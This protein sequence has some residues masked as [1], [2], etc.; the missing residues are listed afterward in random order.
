MGKL[1]VTF[2][3]GLACSISIPEGTPRD[4]VIVDFPESGNRVSIFP[5]SLS[6]LAQTLSRDPTQGTLVLRVE[7]ECTGQDGRDTTYENN[8]RLSINRDAGRA[9]WQFF[10]TVREIESHKR[11]VA[12]YPVVPAENIQSNPLVRRCRARWAYNGDTIQDLSFGGIPSILITYDAWAGV[13]RRLA[14]SH[15]VPV[16]RSF[17]LDA[18][19]F[20]TSGDPTRTIIMA[21]AAW[22]IALREYLRTVGGKQQ[23]RYARAAKKKQSIPNLLKLVE[24][25]KERPI[26]SSEAEQNRESMKIER[27]LVKQLP[28]LRNKL[29]HEGRMDLPEGRA[30]RY[31]LAVFEAV[32]WLFQ[33]T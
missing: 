16:Y 1:E 17:L 6:T 11:I 19:Y 7:R 27:E 21:Y 4:P 14:E 8:E 22:E 23:S 26:F 18:C 3:L 33:D 15:P 30:L 20:G 25:A 9:L 24:A 28:R 5:P 10:E 13:V 12:G 29:V 32:D 31:A 2:Q